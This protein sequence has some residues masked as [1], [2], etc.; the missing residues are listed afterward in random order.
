MKLQ[1]IKTGAGGCMVI[2]PELDRLEV[3]L[4]GKIKK[5]MDKILRA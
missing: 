3:H 5:Y 4:I 1:H 2:N